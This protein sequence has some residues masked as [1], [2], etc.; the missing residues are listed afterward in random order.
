MA[1]TIINANNIPKATGTGFEGPAPDVDLPVVE[2]LSTQVE[3]TP[4][5]PL[6]VTVRPSR[7]A[8]LDEVEVPTPEE[9]DPSTKPTTSQNTWE[10]LRPVI[11][12]GASRENMR[13]ELASITGVSEDD[14]DLEIIKATSDR[15]KHAI[16]NGGTE[17]DVLNYMLNKGYDKEVIKSSL[18]FA[19]KGGNWEI[20]AWKPEKDPA[21]AQK[22]VNLYDNVFSKYSTSAK[23]I[24]GFFGDAE[25]AKGYA[26]DIAELD[27]SMVVY[28]NEQGFNA[29]L[30]PVTGSVMITDENGMVQDVSPEMLPALWHSK[31]EAVGAIAG[32]LSGGYAGARAGAVATAPVPIPQVKA[33]GVVGGGV[34][35]AAVGGYTGAAAGRGLDLMQNSAALKLELEGKFYASQMHEAGLADIIIGAG[36]GVAFKGGKAT[37][38][39][40]AR[41]VLKARDTF[42][43]GNTNGAIKVL[44]E[45]LHASDGQAQEIIKGFNERLQ[46]PIQVDRFFGQGEASPNEQ[47]IAALALTQQ[48]ATGMVRQALSKNPKAANAVRMAI[49]TRAK[50][51][52]RVIQSST[53][54]NIGALIRKDLDAYRQDVKDFYGIIKK[55]G[56]DQVDGTDFLFD[57]NKLAVDPLIKTIRKGM[58]IKKKESILGHIENIEAA[59]T[60]RTFSGLLDFR[61][62]LNDIKYSGDLK[63]TDVKAIDDVLNKIDPVIAKAAKKYMADGDTWNANWKLAK[64]E[65]SQMKRLEINNMY[66]AIT[67][68]KTERSIQLSLNRYG[69][70]LDVDAAEFNAVTARLSP[71]TKAKTEIAALNNLTRKYTLGSK[72]EF[73]AVDFL[74]LKDAAD[75]LNFS[76]PEGRQFKLLLDDMAKLYK[77][78]PILSRMSGGIE[79]PGSSQILATSLEGAAQR[80]LTSVVWNEIRSL[81]PGKI[82]NQ[83]ALIKHLGRVLENPMHSKSVEEFIKAMPE[84]SQGEARSLVKELQAQA[85]KAGPAAAPTKVKMYKRTANGK[86]SVSDGTLGKGVYLVDKVSNPQTATKIVSQDVDLSRMATLENIS[87]LVGHDV[88]EKE[89]RTIP[90]LQQQLRDAG[91]LGI[92]IDNKAMLFPEQIPGQRFTKPMEERIVSRYAPVK[93]TANTI[94]P[95]RS[96]FHYVTDNEE[97]LNAYGAS[98]GVRNDFI[99]PKN[100]KILDL[101]DEATARKVF[102]DIFNNKL[103]SGE[104][105]LDVVMHDLHEGALNIRDPAGNWTAKLK[106]YMEKNGYQAQSYN[107]EEAWLPGVLKDKK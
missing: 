67:N 12:S 72:S 30:N 107:G 36:L 59:T 55:E 15:I 1:T 38:K 56:A 93:E 39:T 18:E 27:N 86:L 75:E 77:N 84:R 28:L 29:G 46:D 106:A 94:N 91:Y 60:N 92:K 104:N 61:Q 90:G 3:D 17:E 100:A 10:T 14:A 9:I 45:N 42:L 35:G 64:S 95:T 13:K 11:E 34:I 58:D 102:K 23:G 31:Y 8:E 25:A 21:Q 89:I 57:V 6:H 99:A 50:D 26:D 103:P 101:S 22:L 24:R 71:A 16:K 83:K 80:T 20:G 68:A 88:T 2:G 5:E 74:K 54:E 73:Q 66:K 82:N 49:D 98:G 32:G 70:D 44:K 87:T 40:A 62:V 19:K 52:N 96:D 85:A 69:N 81:L 7:R 79:A 47:A 53:D 43:A 78:D 65:Y 48:G 33:A 105:E 97:I 41:S 37:Y 76:T 4:R 51:L 63:A